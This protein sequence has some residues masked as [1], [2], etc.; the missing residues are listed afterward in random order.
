MSEILRLESVKKYFGGTKAVDGFSAVVKTG[1]ITGLIGPNGCGKTTVFNLITGFLKPDS[2]D[3]LF[4]TPSSPATRPSLLRTNPHLIVRKGIA[5]TFQEMRLIR[6]MTAVEH[7][8]LGFPNNSGES[9]SGALIGK[10]SRIDRANSAKVD[11]IIEFVQLN[12]VRRHPASEISYGQQKLLS[13][14]CV[15][16]LSPRLLLLDEPFSGLSLVMVG[17]VSAVL[18][19]LIMKGMTIFF[20]EHNLSAVRDVCDEVIVMI[21]GKMIMQGETSVILN[22]PRVA[23][24]FFS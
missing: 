12:E 2:G 22:D 23:Q 24:A 20:I 1:M 18:K 10:G 17:R 4:R 13:I 6:K 15:L 9:V 19:S 3:I 5:R 8:F 11:E 7:V 14:G 21:E 16:A